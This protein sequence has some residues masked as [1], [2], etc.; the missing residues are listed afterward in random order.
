MK[1]AITLILCF[2]LGCFGFVACKDE[3]PTPTPTPTVTTAE[4]TITYYAIID[5]TKTSIPSAMHIT[6]GSYPTT[7]K[8]GDTVTFD[9]LQDYSDGTTT[10]DFVG[11]YTDM[12]C[13]EK[14][15]GT[16]SAGIK[17]NIVLY[18]KIVKSVIQDPDE[19]YWTKNY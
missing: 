11:W 9:M 6:N 7:Y 3:T 1:R 12:T 14:V 13:T 10:Y 17:G 2:I 4:Y 5:G 15:E 16:L 8:E 19:G 18:A